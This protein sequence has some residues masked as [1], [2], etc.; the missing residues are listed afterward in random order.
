M[1]ASLRRCLAGVLAIVLVSA[2]CGIDRAAPTESK[3]V[4]VWAAEAD[5]W[6]DAM[7]SEPR[8][9]GGAFWRYLLDP[10]VTYD[11]RSMFG[12][13]SINRGESAF[14]F[15]SR[16][17]PPGTNA[18]TVESPALIS[19]DGVVSLVH[20]DW[21][22]AGMDTASVRATPAHMANL[23]T[24][25]G[26]N[27][28][29]SM[30]SAMASDSWRE[31]HRRH[32]EPDEA[33]VIA[34]RWVDLWSNHGT[35]TAVLYDPDAVVVDSIAGIRVE[36]T[37]EISAMALEQAPASWSIGVLE[38]GT[39]TVY[40]ISAKAPGVLG[41]LILVA[42][43]V[44]GGDCPGRVAVV[45][46]VAEGKVVSENRFW[47]IET[48]RSCLAAEVLPRGWWEGQE[49]NFDEPPVHTEDLETVTARVAVDGV[50]VDI[51]NGT[52]GLAAAVRWAL[53][54]YELAGLP[55]PEPQSIT[56]TEYSD[57]CDLGP[58]RTRRTK[59]GWHLYFCFCEED[60]CPNDD[61]TS[62]ALIPQHVVLH[63]LAHV[64][65]NANLTNETRTNFMA[66]VELDVWVDNTV[67]WHEQ[68]G[69]YS[70]EVVAW[71]L[72][73]RPLILPKFGSPEQAELHFLF[74]LLTGQKPLRPGPE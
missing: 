51:Y 9:M 60:I 10:K 38:D 27:G 56:F 3:S 31:R 59:Q 8:E 72:F 50:G 62:F 7:A 18:S 58:G 70:A 69:E 39:A 29:R 14:A 21:A 28:A 25:F 23:L 46:T 52:E 1:D 37:G 54:R 45:L 42:D 47:E 44:D 13:D 26:R 61:Y 6:T 2:S 30:V 16:I 40:P 19:T 68:A 15:L 49:L 33:D 12:R 20:L 71:G 24:S 5:S 17:L 67:E 43:R 34:A 66:A 53:H 36:G 74:E 11:Y 35:G 65:L 41:S 48:A 4:T 32:D 22:P 57:F 73:D 55:I 63:E 64:W